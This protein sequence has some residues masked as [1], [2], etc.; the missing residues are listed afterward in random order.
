MFFLAVILAATPCPTREEVARVLT[1]SVRQSVLEQH[2]WVVTSTKT[3]VLVR[4]ETRSG[5]LVR[6]RV[7]EAPPGG[8][9]RAQLG[10]TVLAAWMMEQPATPAV[11]V[12]ALDGGATLEASPRTS[13]DAGVKSADSASS[14]RAAAQPSSPPPRGS[15]AEPPP[16][17]PVDAGTRVSV[18]V[19]VSVPEPPPRAVVVERPVPTALAPVDRGSS[20]SGPREVSAR[21]PTP[22]NVSSSMVELPWAWNASVDVRAQG[23]GTVTGALGL[24]VGGGRALG[25]F[26]ELTGALPR[27]VELGAGSVT[28]NRFGAALGVRYQPPWQRV[29]LEPGLSIEV[30]ALWARTAGYVRNDSTVTPDLAGCAHL[31]AGGRFESVTLFTGLKGCWWPTQT[32]VEVSG[33]VGFVALPTLEASALVGIGFDWVKGSTA[34]GLSDSQAP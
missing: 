22:T 18:V 28:W 30:A 25:G 5:V 1:R 11:V 14:T 21:A 4:L 16:P 6:E 10:G 24:R 9:Q 34:S 31:R 32:R 29:L 15:I 2:T 19:P 26:F 3:Q 8:A 27:S 20:S 7:L 23:S 12:E 17:T 33:V 13:P